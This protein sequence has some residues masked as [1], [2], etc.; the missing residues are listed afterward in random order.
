MGKVSN[1]RSN[2]LSEEISRPSKNRNCGMIWTRSVSEWAGWFELHGDCAPSRNGRTA[3]SGCH[4]RRATASEGW[5]VGD[6]IQQQ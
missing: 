6:E 1:V 4:F 2:R 5:L 3:S